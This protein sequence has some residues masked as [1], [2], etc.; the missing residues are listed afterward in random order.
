MKEFFL[1]SAQRTWVN[2]SICGSRSQRVF[3]IGFF[4]TSSPCVRVELKP[5]EVKIAHIRTDLLGNDLSITQ[6]TS[7]LQKIATFQMA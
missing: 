2:G 5:S 6:N 7:F 1:L 4:D 3:I